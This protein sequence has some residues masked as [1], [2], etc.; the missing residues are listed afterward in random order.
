MGKLTRVCVSNP[1]CESGRVFLSS[2]FGF[3]SGGNSHSVAS[4]WALVF[5]MNILGLKLDCFWAMWQEPLPPCSGLKSLLI[6]RTS[7]GK[8]P[9]TYHHIEIT[10]L[11]IHISMWYCHVYTCMYIHLT[12]IYHLHIYIYIQL[13]PYMYSV[14]TYMCIYVLITYGIPFVRIQVPRWSSNFAKPSPTWRSWTR[15][16]IPGA[17]TRRLRPMIHMG[18]LPST[19]IDGRSYIGLSTQKNR[20]F[21]TKPI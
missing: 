18:V 1:S 19:S 16:W 21:T 8:E 6:G 11:H 13:Y 5:S 12:I 7:K 14:Y 20:G 9:A 17:D 3:G 2:L 15:V 10:R 4:F